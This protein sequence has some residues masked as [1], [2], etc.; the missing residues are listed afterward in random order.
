MLAASVQRWLRRAPS[1][2]LAANTH[3]HG[4]T[5]AADAPA[6]DVAEDGPIAEPPGVPN[7]W[8]PDRLAVTNKLWGEGFAWPGGEVETMR[9]AHPLGLSSAA[10]LLL[11][12]A[13]GGGAAGCI[14]RNLGAWVTG[15]EVEP[16]LVEQ[17]HALIKNAALGKRAT[18]EFWDPAHPDMPVQRFHHCLAI[19]P[20]RCGGEPAQ[21]LASMVQSLKVGGQ[22][23]MTEICAD[24]ALKTDDPKVVRWSKLENRALSTLHPAKAISRMLS[25]AG[26]DVRVSEDVSA[27]HI[28]NALMGWRNA[29]RELRH[30]KPSP[31]IT[32]RLVAEAEI[33]LLRV[34]LLH[35]HR[36]RMM[37]WNAISN[38]V[39]TPR[40]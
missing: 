14:A 30:N 39:A 21:I 13:G 20:L 19:E 25:R 31:A 36:L 34:K 35:E 15:L 12:G 33:W 10:S 29:V 23:V 1:L 28:E 6:T 27:R 38:A 9:L 7:A 2:L 11:V 17:A 40:T 8:P 22:L 4:A 16:A 32:A 5:L 26:F 37:R 24:E 18:V 3:M